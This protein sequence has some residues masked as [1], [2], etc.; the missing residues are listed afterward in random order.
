MGQ[1]TMNICKETMNFIGCNVTSI[2]CSPLGNQLSNCNVCPMPLSCIRHAHGG[3]VCT[4]FPTCST[5]T[6]KAIKRPT[7]AEE[8]SQEM[9]PER[10]LS[11]EENPLPCSLSIAQGNSPPTYPLPRPNS[12]HRGVGLLGKEGEH[13]QDNRDPLHRRSLRVPYHPRSPAQLHTIPPATHQ[14]S[15][16][17]GV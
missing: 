7:P 14:S 4:P 6:W 10:E 3:N 17:S 5:P 13:Q 8:H 16:A 12:P 2:L 1:C 9:P 15:A 11:N